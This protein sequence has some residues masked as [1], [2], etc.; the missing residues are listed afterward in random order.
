MLNFSL[1]YNNFNFFAK[2]KAL[3]VV[4]DWNNDFPIAIEVYT[5]MVAHFNSVLNPLIYGV[6]DPLILKGYKNVFNLIMKRSN[7]VQPI[8][9]VSKIQTVD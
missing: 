8:S 2:Y 3:V 4:S 9:S 1:F 7:K 5:I 6:F